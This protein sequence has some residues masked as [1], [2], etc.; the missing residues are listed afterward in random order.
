MLQ[1]TNYE[2]VYVVVFFVKQKTAYE[3]RISDWSS[4]VCSS[5]LLQ[6]LSLSWHDRVHTG[7]LMTRGILDIEGVR[8]WFDT[9]V[10]R[11][12]L[13]T[14]LIGGGAVVLFR[15][16]AGL[17]L[18]ALSFVPIVGVRASIARL[19]LRDTWIALQD[20]MSLL[21]KVM[22][23]NLGG[24]RVV[25]AFAA[26]AHEMARFDVISDSALAI[27]TR[28][29]RLF[30]LSTTQMTFVYF[31]AMALT[32][33]V[34]GTKVAAGD[35][36]LGQFAEAL[37]FMLILQMPVR[38]IGWMINSIARASTCGGRL[39]NVLDLVPSIADVPGAPDLVV[40]RSEDRRGG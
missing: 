6:T 5:D 2:S 1:C 30:V 36:T 15:N 9:G 29:V 17:A 19:R 10:L 25:R 32:L 39:F 26:Q 12:I 37:A 31:L 35:I 21:T 33:W 28:R 23:E 24:I 34:G 14:V 4:D 3:W 20:Q 27:A 38:Q 13:L 18:A 8:L 22:E 7:Y 11:S 16:D 40:P